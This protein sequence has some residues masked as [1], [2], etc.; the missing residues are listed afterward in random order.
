MKSKLVIFGVSTT[1]RAIYKFV[2]DY[3]LFDIIGFVQ[4]KEYKTEESYCGL[5]VYDFESLSTVFDKTTDY[6]FIAVEWNHLNADRRRLYNRLKAKSYRLANIISPTALIHGTIKG[7]NCWICDYVVVENDTE[8]GSDILVKPKATLQHNVVVDDH[9]FIAAHTLIA[10]NVHIGEQSYLGVASVVFNGVN[11]GR[12]CIV[13]GG[14]TVKR[15]V[16]DFTVIKTPNDQ[17]VIKTYNEE[18]IENKL[19]ASIKIR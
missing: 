8:I 7:D 5:Q 17:F 1:A 15:H 4:D 13:G 10:G 2:K 16:P 18:E 11:I 14:V 9:C 3:D 12:K 19:L 6:M